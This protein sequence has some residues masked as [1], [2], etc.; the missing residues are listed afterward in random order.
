MKIKNLNKSTYRIICTYG[1]KA[2]I[3]EDSKQTPCL[4]RTKKKDIVTNDFVK[5]EKKQNTVLIT[6]IK[7]RKNI[8]Y[9]QNNHKKKIIV[10]N[11]D[12]IF[13]VISPVPLFSSETLICMLASAQ[14]EKIP[15]SIIIN[16]T[17][18]KNET[19]KLKEIL[20]LITPFNLENEK[21][22]SEK[23]N[24][25]EFNSDLK[26]RIL[27]CNTKTNNGMDE[28]RKFIS[29]VK[30]NQIETNLALVG[31]SGTGK[32]SI[33]NS[34]IPDAN[35]RVS[36]ISKSLNTGRHT[37]TTSKSY[38][39]EGLKNKKTWMIDTPG[40]EKFGISHLDMNDLKEVFTDWKLINEKYGDCKYANCFHGSE[41][42]CQ[43]KKLLSML[44]NDPNSKLRF[45]NL[46]TRIK[47]WFNLS[48]MVRSK[49]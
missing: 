11:I 45:L 18:L 14:K 6:E 31:Q 21:K 7:N 20:T 10:A 36:A 22:D 38:E 48:K 26:T 9:R 49:H 30:N 28:F 17:D 46:R 13:I 16:K 24:Q 2:I 37:T 39:I 29:K 5:I 1:D 47:I 12:H 32:S 4:I 40:I 33:V 8:F 23:L 25:Y 15:T 3:D 19:Q 43:I 41:P 34:L 44:S 42:N 27:S 35:S